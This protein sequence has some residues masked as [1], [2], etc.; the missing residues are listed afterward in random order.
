[1]ATV[2]TRRHPAKSSQAIVETR[3]ITK[4]FD[5]SRV[6]GIDLVAR[7]GEF[8]VLLGPSGCGKTTLLRMIAGLEKQTSGDVVIGGQVVN[9]LPPRARK[10]A[11]V[12]QSYALYPHLTVEK[13]ISFPLKAQRHPARRRSQTRFA[14]PPQRSA[15]RSLLH[16]KPRQL[17]GGERQRV[18]LARAMVRSPDVFLLDEPLSNLDAKLRMSARDELQAVPAP[19]RDHHHLRHA[20]SGRGDGSRRPHR[21]DERGPV[22]QIGNPQ[23]VYD[24]PAD[25]FVAS[26]LGSPPMNFFERRRRWS[27]SGPSSSCRRRLNANGDHCRLL[28]PVNRIENLGAD[29][30]LYGRRC[31]ISPETR[32]I[33]V[34]LP[35]EHSHARRAGHV[36]DFVDAP[37][38]SH[39]SSTARAACASTEAR[40]DVSDHGDGRQD[41]RT[42][43]ARAHRR[44]RSLAWRAMLAPAIVY[45]VAAGRAAVLLSLC[46]QLHERSISLRRT[47][48]SSGWKISGAIVESGTFWLAAAIPSVITIVRRS[49]CSCSPT[50]WPRPCRRFSRQMAGAPADPVAVGRAGVAGQHRLV[51]DVRFDLQRHQ[52]DAAPVACWFQ[53]VAD[54]AGPAAPGDVG[55]H[56]GPGLAHAA[57]GDGDSA[58]R[59]VV[60]SAGHS[61]RRGDRRRRVLRHLF[62]ITLPLVM[63]IQLVAL[64]FGFVFAFTDMIV[65]Y[66]LTRGGPYDSTQVL[67]SWRSSK[68]STAAIWR[69][70]PPSRCSCCRCWPAAILM[71]CARPARR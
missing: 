48:L 20:R 39:A 23:E 30:L 27:A 61:R 15:S 29:R 32:K 31:A 50:S 56:H 18:A 60:D 53:R 4:L 68:G 63:P 67:A 55:D 28:V 17:S 58:R 2:E 43:R 36:Y 14:R 7:E 46:L 71:G 25:I 44:Q 16:R 24:E 37:A 49:W 6:D 21:G 1:M 12:F 22:R 65:M 64:L 19:P 40:H 10:I 52:L 11:M 57:A 66:V 13:N 47:C 5:G 45:I 41:P 51:V 70:E 62:Q 59:A 38:G 42:D 26:F 54:L 33:I 34:K 3:R 9:D 69:A 8:L 35:D